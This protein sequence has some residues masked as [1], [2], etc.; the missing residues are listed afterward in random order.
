MTR[1]AVIGTPRSG[2]TWLRALLADLANAKQTAVHRPDDVAWDDLKDDGV[3]Q[4]H[5][6]PTDSFLELLDRHDFR[7]VSMARHPLD[8]LISVLQYVRNAR[9]THQWLDGAGGTEEDLIGALPTDPATL[10]YGTSTRFTALLATTP[11]WW[12]RPETVR[13]RYEDLVADT[14]QELSRIA[15]ELGIVGDIEAS[16]NK[17]SLTGLRSQYP[18]RSFHFWKGSP[19]L[20][21]ELLTTETAQAIAQHQAAAFDQLGYACEAN[22]TLTPDGALANWYRIDNDALTAQLEDLRT[23][24]EAVGRRPI[25]VAIALRQWKDRFV[26]P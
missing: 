18:L 10:S 6:M 3:L 1:I 24:L 11:A 16:V 22:P 13:S 9:E 25:R 19:G 4:I 15:A 17:N 20:W 7:V 26:K 23:T 12:D 21:R 2:N 14:S 5:W 8:V